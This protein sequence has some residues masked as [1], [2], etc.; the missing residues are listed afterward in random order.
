MS[1]IRLGLGELEAVIA[2]ARRASFRQA[3][4]DLDVSTTALSNTI[5]KVEA[6]LETRL[7]NRTTRSVAVTE[8]GRIFLEQV[9]PALQDVRGALDAVRSHNAGASGTLRINA[10]ATAARATLLPLLVEF[11]KLHPKVH[12]D[13]VTEGRLVDIVA[14]GFDFGVR[15]AS[16]VPS[17]MI[18]ISLS[19]PR[20]YAV[21][22]T[23]AYFARH[24]R[25][26]TPPDLLNHACIRIR[27]PNGAL[28]PWHFERDDEVIKLDVAGPLTLDE[29]SVSKA[30]VQQGLGLGFF[31]EQDVQ[32]EIDSGEFERVLEDWTPPR[33][34]LCLYYPNRRNPSA[35]FKAFIALVRAS[36]NGKDGLA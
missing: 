21:V 33:D 29:A 12:V 31:M 13:L 11:L 10:F 25:P 6:S 27:L 15:S 8:A 5:A 24:G 1:D 34:N 17:D 35:A 30:V 9:G 18:V 36:Q 2:V 14:D 20:R 19:Q 28:F 23:P 22:G 7:F 4:I 3:A 32:A 26:R 16:L